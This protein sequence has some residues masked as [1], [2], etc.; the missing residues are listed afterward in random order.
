MSTILR[1][2]PPR[3]HVNYWVRYIVKKISFT[4]KNTD[5]R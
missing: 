2:F 1:T 4:Y 5:T 3:L